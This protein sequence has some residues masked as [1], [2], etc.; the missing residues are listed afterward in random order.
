MLKAIEIIDQNSK[1]GEV[2]MVPET[3]AVPSRREPL[4]VRK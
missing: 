3:N 2:L 1:P 4:L